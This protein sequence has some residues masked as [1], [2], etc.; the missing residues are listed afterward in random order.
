MTLSKNIETIAYIHA[1]ACFYKQAVSIYLPAEARKYVHF[2]DYI[3]RP[4]Q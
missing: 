1:L 2:Q 4:K 3:W